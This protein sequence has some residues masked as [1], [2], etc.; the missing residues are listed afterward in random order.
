MQKFDVIIIGSGPSGSVAA[1]Y[2]SKNGFRT[3]LIER[4]TLPRNKT[5]GGGLTYK[6]LD[7]LKPILDQHTELFETLCYSTTVHLNE[8]QKDFVI[9]SDN[10]IMAN[11]NRSQFDYELANKAVE[12]G[13]ILKTDEMFIS[14]EEYHSGKLKI[15]TN[16][17]SYLCD[18]LIAGDGA[19]SKVRRQLQKEYPLLFSPFKF[20]AGSEID[21]PKNDIKS[22]T[23]NSTHLFFNFA[24]DIDYGWAFPKKEYIN[25]GIGY[26][27]KSINNNNYIKSCLYKLI[28]NYSVSPNIG[29]KINTA[30]LPIFWNKTFPNIQWGKIL[31]VGD[32][33][34]LVDEW[35]GEGIYYSIKSSI[36]AYETIRKYYDK[37]N[38][39][40]IL[41]WYTKK[42]KNEFFTNLTYSHYFAC[43]FRSKPQGYNYLSSRRL[44]DL[45]IPFATGK[46]TYKSALLKAAP[47]VILSK[48]KKKILN[49]ISLT[50]LL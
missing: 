9:K 16:R 34:G 11:V 20:L 42:T 44:R 39:D 36:Y 1:Y 12:N 8:I 43:L 33:A 41:Y 35:T 6:S 21:I 26:K 3:L 32:A 23:F 47:I 18:F 29:Y 27:V 17:D 40:N 25:F 2:C 30:L 31:L 4:H 5:C 45:F 14:F 19:T 13:T 46:I 49:K 50:N 24:P 15:N 22:L 37:R 48:I 28:N 38:N 10:V 7:L